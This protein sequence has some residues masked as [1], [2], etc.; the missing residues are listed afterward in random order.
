M[1]KS[2]VFDQFQQIHELNRVFLGMLQS[3]VRQNRSCLGLPAAAHGALA[4]AGSATLEGVAVFPRALFQL[5]LAVAGH[6]ARPG[7]GGGTVDEDEHDVCFSILFAARQLSRESAY[8]SRLLFGLEPAGIEQLR[9]VA[10]GVLQQLA[11]VPG[12]LQCAYREQP[13]LWYGLLTATR[14][15]LRRQLTLLALQPRLRAAWP[16]RRPPQPA[17]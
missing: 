11:G 9:G 1:Q 5:D 4:A 13:W 15:E 14:P 17:A 6:A 16:Q 12:V 3:R 2:G 10:L 7:A 8:R